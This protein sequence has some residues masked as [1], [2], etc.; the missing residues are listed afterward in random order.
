MRNVLSLSF[1]DAR[2][3]AEA[4]IDAARRRD[5]AVSIAVA[6]HAGC[7]LHFSRM[8][9]ARMHTIDLACSKARIAAQVGVPTVAIEHSFAQRNVPPPAGFPGAGGFPV[10]RDGECAGAL[11]VSGAS[12]EIDDLIAKAGLATLAR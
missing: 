7:L 3:I 9:A 2:K 10:L 12:A 5:S 8:D 4:C 6:D 1:E 11:G